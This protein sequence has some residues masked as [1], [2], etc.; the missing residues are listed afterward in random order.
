MSEQRSLGSVRHRH[1]LADEGFLF[2]LVFDLVGYQQVELGLVPRLRCGAPDYHLGDRANVVCQ[3]GFR[4]GED[5]RI[6]AGL[7]ASYL[8]SLRAPSK[9]LIWFERSAHNVPFE[10]PERFNDA[11]LDAVQSIGIGGEGSESS[12]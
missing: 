8:E 6:E 11:V 4:L 1:G 2:V 10:E 9:K 12:Q 7:A 5:C 3:P